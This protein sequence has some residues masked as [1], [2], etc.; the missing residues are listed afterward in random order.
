MRLDKFLKVSQIIKRRTTAQFEIE[1]G[2]VMLNYRA[3]KSSSEVKVGDV[4]MTTKDN[5]KYRVLNL[6]E[7]AT[8][9]KAKTMYEV[10]E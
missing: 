4:I 6:Y 7:S 10:L 2:A 5:K 9:E 1:N 3:A 8:A